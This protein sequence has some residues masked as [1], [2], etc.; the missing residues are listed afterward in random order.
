M[1][2]FS[3]GYLVVI[4]T[5]LKEIGQVGFFT[6]SFLIHI[7]FIWFIAGF[8]GFFT[9]FLWHFQVYFV[10]SLNVLQCLIKGESCLP[11]ETSRLICRSTG[12]CIIAI[13]AYFLNWKLVSISQ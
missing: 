7:V 8:N 12:S 6:K 5:H 11:I 4:S 10:V 9:F 1:I 13:L 3:T 2:G